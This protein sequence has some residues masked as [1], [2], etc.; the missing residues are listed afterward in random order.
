MYLGSGVT[1][2][3]VYPGIVNTN[4]LRNSSFSKSWLSSIFLKPILWLFIKNEKQGSQPLI[5]AAIEPDLT[6]VSGYLFG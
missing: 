3:A 6:N 1:V 4:L 5:Y 2:N